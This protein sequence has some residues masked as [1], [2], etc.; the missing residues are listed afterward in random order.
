MLASNIELHDSLMPSF[1]ALLSVLLFNNPSFIRSFVIT[2][3]STAIPIPNTKAAIPGSVKTPPT[4]QKIPITRSIYKINNRPSIKPENLYNMLINN[5]TKIV[6]IK[7]AT[8]V[9]SKTPFP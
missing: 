4:S 8:N 1:K 6:P 5:I 7:P 9:F 2:Q 3:E